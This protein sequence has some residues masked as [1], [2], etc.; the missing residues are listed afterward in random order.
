RGARRAVDAFPTR[1]SSD[2]GV[3]VA[4]APERTGVSTGFTVVASTSTSASVGPIDGT[5]RLPYRMASGGPS[6]STYAAIIVSGAVT[7]D[8]LR[9]RV[10]RSARPGC[11][12]LVL[13]DA[14]CDG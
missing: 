4:N 7:T 3:G 11:G 13:R 1:R 10:F 14:R 12:W 2:L 6:A 5:G 9:S 8:S